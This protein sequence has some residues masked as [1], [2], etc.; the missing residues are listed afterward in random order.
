MLN[1]HAA[2]ILLSFLLVAC[3][4][5]SGGTSSITPT[6]IVTPPL[7]STSSSIP[8][9]T[10][11][12]LPPTSIP[13]P[14]RPIYTLNTIID[15]DRHFVSVD[16]IIL[17]PNHTGERLEFLTLAIAANLWP[18]CFRLERCCRARRQR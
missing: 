5:P 3:Q 6:T 8:T 11:T 4:S 9:T 15:Y 17:Y 10:P 1:K 7:T 13:I 14:P 2:T 12:N 16:E 18:N